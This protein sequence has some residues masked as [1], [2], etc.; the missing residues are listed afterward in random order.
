MVGA[1]EAAWQNKAIPSTSDFRGV[2]IM[3]LLAAWF[4]FVWQFLSLPPFASLT[5][6]LPALLGSVLAKGKYM[7]NCGMVVAGFAAFHFRRELR[8]EWDRR[9]ALEVYI[10]AVVPLIAYLALGIA[11]LEVVHL[12][13]PAHAL[14]LPWQ[15]RLMRVQFLV[16]ATVIVFAFLWP[17]FLYWMWTAVLDIGITGV[18]LAL[19]Y[20][21][22]SLSLG[23]DRAVFL[24]P[25]SAL[26]SFLLG[27]CLCTT[28][29]R[30]A[31]YLAPV[32]GTMI[33]LG[34]M[35]MLTCSIVPNA[36]LFLLGF[37]MV[38]GGSALG[39]RSWF[40]PGER[41]L[42][43]WSRTALAIVV[44]QPALFTAWLTW[45][46]GMT[47][48]GWV[49]FLVLA[50]AAQ[51]LATVLCLVIEMPARRLTPAMPA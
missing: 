18:V 25:V 4:Y 9:I 50:V 35:T 17:L 40:L 45:G 41:V 43:V 2:L 29:F 34:W 19:I 26:F 11:L 27:V 5:A 22:M 14:V 12:A 30:S 8:L 3:G 6:S 38:V 42:L 20:Y 24:W 51:L 21:G 23:W 39:E 13:G 28:L 46:E 7:P 47:G 44:V 31:L 32:G 36:A 1:Q 37:L 49:G 33:I 10:S 15:D 16:L 48:I